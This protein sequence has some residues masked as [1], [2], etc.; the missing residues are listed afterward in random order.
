MSAPDLEI[1]GSGELRWLI[2][3]AAA[4]LA[5]VY[6][7][8]TA[9]F[10]YSTRLADGG[11]ANDYT[12]PQTAR[13]TINSLLGVSHASALGMSL[14]GPLAEPEDCVE[15]FV[16]QH[17]ERLDSPA[18]LGLLLLLLSEH[19]GVGGAR[20]AVL[21][22]V[23]DALAE[24]SGR[25]MQDLAWMLWG[26][27]AAARTG[28]ADGEWLAERIFGAILRDFVDPRSGMPRHSLNVLRRHVVSFG[29]IVYFLRALAEYGSLT[30]SRTAEDLFRRGVASTI[31]LQGPHGEWPWMVDTRSGVACDFYPVFTVHQ[32]AMAMLFLFPALDRGLPDVER[33]I[34][35]SVAWGLGRNQLGLRM[36]LSEPFVAFRS[37]HRSGHALRAR[38]YVRSLRSAPAT[39]VEDQ[40]LRVNR[41]CRSYHPGWMLYAWASR[42]LDDA[43]AR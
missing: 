43:A 29:G 13:Y 11:F 10:P 22:R 4:F 17:A 31:A 32:D 2:D 15:Q 27:T 34:T 25:T 24:T 35:H 26:A 21:G 28:S 20:A 42:T 18:D 9:L 33:A 12:H 39:L 19:D 41:E 37:M 38:R 3:G 7:P 1:A 23:R 40:R 5:D 6:D 8:E 16:R 30:G 36:Y 14:A